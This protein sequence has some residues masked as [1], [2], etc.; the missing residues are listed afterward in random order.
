MAELQISSQTNICVQ[1][2]Q[3]SA[4]IKYKSTKYGRSDFTLK[5]TINNSK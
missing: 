3:E 4:R 2:N 1:T 5:L